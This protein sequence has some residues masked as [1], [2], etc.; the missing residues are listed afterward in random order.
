MKKKIIF[1][2]LI[3]I[4]FI[5]YSFA[6]ENPYPQLL[7]PDFSKG[8]VK[9]N[10]GRRMTASLNYNTVDEEM[11]F[12][13]NG[14][15]MALEKP[16]DVDTVYIRNRKFI[17]IGN[18]FFEIASEGTISIFIQSKGKY[19]QPGTPTAY[20]MTSPTAG[21]S[22][23]LAINSGNQV[24]QIELPDNV[25]VTKTNLYWLRTPNGEMHKFTTLRQFIKLFPEKSD[26]IKDFTRQN[27][28]ISLE[29]TDDLSKLGKYIIT[30]F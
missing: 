22:K 6:Q 28:I 26:L 23:V 24:R 9:M 5:T 14:V 18:A 3:S 27:N 29:S 12:N 30:I 20:G 2:F 21:P 10:D 15:Y 19:T 4:S 16:G 13:Q 7:F 11:L 8:I 17:P 1:F 25:S